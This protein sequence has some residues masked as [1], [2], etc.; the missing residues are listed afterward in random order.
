MRFH[1]RIGEDPR[2]SARRRR[3]A[4]TSAW[5]A[6]LDHRRRV[7]LE[8]RDERE[9]ARLPLDARRNLLEQLLEHRDRPLAVS[10]R[11]GGGLLRAGA[12]AAPGRDR[13][14]S[15]SAASSQSS[16][17]AAVRPA[18]RRAA[19]RPR[20]GKRRRRRRGRRPL[21][22]GGGRAPRRPRRPRRAHGGRRGASRAAPAR[23]RSRR[24]AG[25]RSGGA[26]RRARSRPPNRRLER[27]EDA[28]L[29]ARALR[30]PAR[31]SAGRAR[32]PERSTSSGLRREPGEAAAEQLLQA[33]GHGQGLARRR[34]RVR[35]DELA[36]ELEREERD[37]PPS[38]PARGRAR[39]ASGR[40][41]AAPRADGAAAPRLSGPSAD[42][43]RAARRERAIELERGYDVSAC[44]RRV[45]R[46]S[47]ALVTQG[48]GARS[49]AR[50]RR[51]DRATGRR[52]A[53]TT[54]GPR[55]ARS[56]STSS[57]A[58]PI[59]CGSGAAL[60]GLGEQERDLER[61]RRRGASEG[62]ASSRTGGEQLREP[63]ERE[64]SLGLD[65]AVYEHTAETL[66][67]LLDTSLPEDRLA[68]PRLAREHERSRAVRHALEERLD[69]TELL[70]P[71]DDLRGHAR[72]SPWRPHRASW[73]AVCGELGRRTPSLRYTW[74]RCASTV[75]TPM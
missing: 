71:S 25:A 57:R 23:S 42:P 44:L 3:A 74:E 67:G 46:Q 49:A 7:G 9:R 4:S 53:A 58:S 48:A 11:G 45:A 31:P 17:A 61:R 10:R 55:S 50:R 18:C 52:R 62:A 36:A 56:R 65:A 43:R 75:L 64:R 40:A 15:A 2:T 33:L 32:R 13:Q 60:T 5:S 30:R 72:L 29:V 26:S 14:G 38:P 16:A 68:D 73:R 22:P 8:R 39:A 27:L 12:V 70:V 66:A 37:C 21:A 63:G 54:T 1:A 47:D 34:S 24:A 41:R 59:A 6:E 19:R 51:T 20:R 28:L 35:P 69:R